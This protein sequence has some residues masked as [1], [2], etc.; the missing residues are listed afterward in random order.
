MSTT[1]ILEEH[2]TPEHPDEVGHYPSFLAWVFTLCMG[3]TAIL[4]L[5]V[6]NFAVGTS[7]LQEKALHITSVE[8]SLSTSYLNKPPGEVEYRSIQLPDNWDKSAKNFQGY[9]WYRISFDADQFATSKL[10]LM[11]PRVIMNAEVFLN[12]SRIGGQ[13]KMEGQ[14]SR[15]WNRPLTFEIPRD[16]LK[17]NDKTNMLHIQVAGYKNYRSGLSE[18][19]IGPSEVLS[20][21]HNRATRW[22]VDSSLIAVF[23]AFTSGIVILAASSIFSD[24]TGLT[25]LGISAILWS[26]RNI[27]YFTEWIPFEHSLWGQ[28]VHTLHIWFACFFG[29][30]MLD[31]MGWK[32][33]R[34]RR[35]LLLYSTVFTLLIFS[36]GSD[37][38]LS[39][40]FFMLA[41]IIPFMTWL[42]FK[43]L[44]FSSEHR[45]ME[46]MLMAISCLIFLVLSSR[47][48]LIATELL[49]YGNTLLG[50]TS[51]VVLFSA[52]SVL[53]LTRY[54]QVLDALKKANDNLNIKLRQRE[55][56]LLDKFVEIRAIQTERAKE[57]ERRRIMQD[58]H[59]GVGSSLV[60]AL[61]VAESRPLGQ[62]E[63][64]EVLTD[65]LDDLR[66]AIDS[67]DPVSDDLLAVLGNFRWRFEKRLTSAGI[68]LNWKVSDL[69]TLVGYNSRDVFEILKFVQ[70]AFAN[71]LKHAKATELT[72][73]THLDQT[74]TV[75]IE[76]NDNGKGFDVDQTKASAGRGL[77]N[78][79]MRASHLEGSLT[80]K[81]DPNHGSGTTVTLR[82]PLSK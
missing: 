27:G 11:L 60:T 18:F 40:T 43:L 35:F 56:E 20:N 14:L 79:Q 59:D 48:L 7:E 76:V 19:W 4:I 75:C 1:P 73:V 71:A 41:P 45:S 39:F 29:L 61:N 74:G 52:C 72:L 30:F 44:R 80:L 67:L 70:E 54:R 53:V 62:G 34:F 66:F 42:S 82:I 16:L 58:I 25:Y 65:C 5:F 28:T 64:K 68:K 12:G 51:G 21:A 78:M 37:D 3:I 13:G 10:S 17:R 22:Q 55:K 8:R 9:A 63:L 23:L 31:Y 69:P 15:Y 77:K 50:H 24:R 81:S 32:S 6:P 47:D 38:V 26:L 33:R 2:N 46:G 49:H 36:I 57:Q